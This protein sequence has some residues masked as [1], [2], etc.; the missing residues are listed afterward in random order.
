[1][2]V[3]VNLA[4]AIVTGG[5]AEGDE[6]TEIE[7]VI[8]SDYNDVLVG[9]DEANR[10]EG[11][12]GADQLDG[13][14]GIDWVS[15]EWSDAGVTVDL[16][17]GR[18]EGGHA[19]GDVVW[20]IENVTGSE[21][22]DVLSGDDGANSLAGGDGDDWLFGGAGAD[23][24]DGG[25]GMDWL[26]Y[27]GSDGAV[28]VRLYDG[29]AARGHAEGDVINGFENLRGSV[30]ADALAG[31]GRAN[32]LEGGAG[33]DR[34]N[35]GSGD[36]VLEGGAGAD[37]LD[38]GAGMDWLSYAGSDGA[39]SVRLYDGYAARGHAEG[40][41]I[42]GF[43]NLRGSVYADALAGD[44]RANRLEGGDGDDQLWGNSGDDVLEG[45][46]GAD[47]FY[48]GAG[49]D[50]LY[51]G[52]G[53]DRLD[54]G[55]GDD[56][57]FSHFATQGEDQSD[58]SLDVFVF[59]AGH[60]DDIIFHFIDDEDKIDLSAFGLSGYHE[61]TVTS[62]PVSVT[63]DLSEHGGGTI[64]LQDFDIANLDATDFLF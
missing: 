63:I 53:A 47:R 39:V 31:D 41:V 15:Y 29:Y 6:L 51:G 32:R 38:G 24:L 30:Y 33:D 37:R 22:G 57:L 58:E 54:G 62:T 45:G 48:G 23:R 26:S 40:D 7:N 60:G 50:K 56:E 46:A 19:H 20:N 42:N 9:N 12:A 28:S 64:L 8:G 34:L 52:P 2:A 44:G 14:G 4:D 3:T 21:Y 10:L 5:H 27:Q 55:A 43:E 1:M 18:F 17:E 11:G 61:L 36:D 16:G 13:R 59:G 49:D 35:G 25:A